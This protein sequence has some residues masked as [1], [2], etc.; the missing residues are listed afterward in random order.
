MTAEDWQLYRRVRL[1]ALKEAPYAFGSTYEHEVALDDASW[2][3]RVLS[4]VRF[5]AEVDGVVA[6]TV[7]G[8]DTEETGV[9][10]ITAMWVEPRFRRAGAGATLMDTV[11]DWA[12]RQGYSRVSLWVA[13]VNQ[14][15]E[16]LYARH[17][18]L[19]TGARQDIRPGEIEH[20]MALEL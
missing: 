5:I 16:R 12:R 17:G 1:D 7:S 18:F 2:R 9:A 10:A 20:E 8:G 3:Q 19:R 13:E 4:R 6:G 14:S 11:I 15:A